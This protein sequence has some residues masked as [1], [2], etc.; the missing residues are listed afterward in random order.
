LA[1]TGS[2]LAVVSF[3]LVGLDGAIRF[4]NLDSLIGGGRIGAAQSDMVNLLGLMFRLGVAPLPA[5]IIA[6]TTYGMSL[7]ILGV[8][9]KKN[10]LT[11]V[12]IALVCAVFFAPHVH[13]HDLYLLLPAMALAANAL[14]EK[15]YKMAI[16]F[17]LFAPLSL[18]YLLAVPTLVFV[19]MVVFVV[20]L[21]DPESGV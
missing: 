6:W 18:I 12:G 4:V 15:G 3:A 9:R 2:A 20:G 21:L 1:L 11:G 5:R 14:R 8:T 16:C 7:L 10:P 13:F 17:L 19:L